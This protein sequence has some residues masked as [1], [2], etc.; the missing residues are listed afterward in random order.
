MEA[1]PLTNTDDWPEDDLQRVS[2][3]PEHYTDSDHESGKRPRRI[4]LWIQVDRSHILAVE[5][6]AKDAPDQPGQVED[7]L[8]YMESYSVPCKLLYLSCDRDKPSPDSISGDRW[9]N[10]VQRGVA[11]AHCYAAFI[12]DWLERCKT[13]CESDRV[14]FFIDDLIAFVDSSDE[15][16]TMP[17]D[18]ICPEILVLLH[19]SSDDKLLESR[20]E[21]LLSILEHPDCI[22]DEIVGIFQANLRLRLLQI[23]M[24]LTDDVSGLT[25]E[26]WGVIE[27]RIAPSG[28][29]ASYVAVQRCPPV[30]I[31]R[32]IHILP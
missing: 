20:R 6:K 15:R 29:G 28:N 30:I 19:A 8:K 23:G 27:A 1:W 31:V 3:Y 4:D 7:Y 22:F 9:N 26:G 18:E 12:R 2:I 16:L 24:E 5:S 14:R 25:K 13:E 11:E 32:V 17:L 10:A 21:T